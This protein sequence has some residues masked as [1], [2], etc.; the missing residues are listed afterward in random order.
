MHVMIKDENMELAIKEARKAAQETRYL[1]RQSLKN[2]WKNN[3]IES[4]KQ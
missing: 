2:F 1:W 3:A 4:N